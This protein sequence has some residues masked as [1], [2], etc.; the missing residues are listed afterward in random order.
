MSQFQVIGQLL[1]ANFNVTTDQAIPLWPGK[2]GIVTHIVVT[3]ASTSLTLAAGGFYAGAGKTGSIIVAAA[4]VYS[5]LTAAGL[6]LMP[7]VAVPVRVTGGQIFFALTVAQ[8]GVA[9]AD[10]YVCGISADQ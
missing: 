5:A 10:I 7:A 2:A 6:A 8:G 9:T 1:G 3:N 4:Q